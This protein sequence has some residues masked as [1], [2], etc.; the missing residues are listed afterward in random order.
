MLC[1]PVVF[2]DIH[3]FIKLFTIGHAPDND[4]IDS[5]HHVKDNMTY[6][7]EFNKIVDI[8]KNYGIT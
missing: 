1:Y 3:N 6:C 8:L 5:I 2:K 7:K 4:T